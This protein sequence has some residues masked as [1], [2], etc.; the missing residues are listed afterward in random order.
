MSETTPG[1]RAERGGLPVQASPPSRYAAGSA[2]NMARSLLVILVMVAGLVM[3]VPRL[4]AVE[5]PPVDALS[6]VSYA[7]KESKTPFAYPQG[8]P[9]G[10]RATS[11][12]YAAIDGLPTWQA[13][14]TTPDGTW[15][16]I[17]QAVSVGPGWQEA[18]LVSG[19][20]GQPVVA[21]NRTW[22][23]RDDD[24]GQHSLAATDRATGLT[25]VVLV[26]GPV[27]LGTAFI[28]RLAPAPAA[29]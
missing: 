26:S 21:G 5:Q 11:A 23:R 15:V 17:R 7:V 29:R 22:E 28:E 4:S 24:K 6:V 18:V 25:T 13:G 14:W 8:L 12:R 19:P 9:D 16:G 3:L 10:W 2:A 20:V 27:E 1:P